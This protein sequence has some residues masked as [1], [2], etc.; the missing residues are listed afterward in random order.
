MSYQLESIEL[1]VRELPPDRLSFG[2]GKANSDGSAKATAKRRPSAILLVRASVSRAGEEAVFGFSGDRPSFGWLD[3][4]TE[5]S[6]AKK[7]TMLLDLVENSRRI[8]LEKGTDFESPFAL[9]LEASSAVAEVA[10]ERSCEELMASYA[11]ALMERAV[12]DAVCRAEGRSFHEMVCEDRL[13][14]DPGSIHAELEGIPFE[15]IFPREPQTSFYVRHTVGLSDPI[16][17]EDWPEEKRINDGEPETLEEYAVRDGLRYF[18]IKISGDPGADLERLGQI[19]NSVLVGTDR[20]AVTL[21]GNESYT[22]IERFAEFVDRFEAVHPGLF[23]HTLFIEQ[24]LTRAVTLDPSTA[25]TVRRI[26]KKKALVIDEADG[27]TDAFRRAFEIGYS[28]CSH[29]NC[30]GVFKS[31]LNF[32]LIHQWSETTDREL[33]LSGEDL[34]NMPIVPLHQDF[35]ALGMLGVEHCERNGHHY[36]FGLSH[37]TEREKEAVAEEHSDLY[38]ERDGELFLRIEEGMVE[39]ASVQ[40]KAFGT[41]THPE[42]PSMVSL[43]EWRAA[44]GA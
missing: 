7:L 29:K 11:S 33:F 36:A 2:I 3:K 37:L 20:P 6:S 23:Q 9:W 8:Y 32:A 10:R 12:I 14:I 1:A 40:K 17:A 41:V 25:E 34:S 5:I 22:D 27:T 26:A 42:W 15:R 28:G 18:K 31:L 43:A 35:A 39:A 19:W 16:T 38:V 44:T 13:G 30:K 24:P 4:R 21:D